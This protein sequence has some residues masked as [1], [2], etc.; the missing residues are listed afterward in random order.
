M[1]IV[2]SQRCRHMLE[3]APVAAGAFQAPP[4]GNSLTVERVALTR[5]VLVRIQVPQPIPPYTPA[6]LGRDPDSRIFPHVASVSRHSTAEGAAQG[7]I[8]GDNP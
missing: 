6:A 1:G 8:T 7:G 2:A 5:L 3:T 4:L